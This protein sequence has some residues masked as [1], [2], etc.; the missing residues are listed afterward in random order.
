MGSVV[1]SRC[2][3]C[4]GEGRI[5]ETSKLKAVV[6]NA[7]DGIAVLT[8]TGRV[9]LWSPALA[10]ITGISEAVAMGPLADAPSAL[11][12][13][14]ATALVDLVIRELSIHKR[15]REVRFVAGLPR[16]EMGKVQKTRLLP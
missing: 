3:K 4:G 8:G 16:N 12:S 9:R 10:R 7:S 14:L 5:E 6:E 2:K 13:V 11:T 1:E 15:P